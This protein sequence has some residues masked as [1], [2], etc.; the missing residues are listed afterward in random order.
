MLFHVPEHVGY[1]ALFLLIFIECAGVPVPGE[2]ALLTAGVLAGTGRLELSLVIATA[3]A[4]AMLGDNMGYLI[5]RHG[6]RRVL[7]R[8]GPMRHHRVR[9]VE[10]GEAFFA[11]HGAKTVFVGRWIAGV[12]IAGAV[13]A[14]ASAMPWRVFLVFNALG[15]IAWSATVAGFAAFAGPVATGTLYVAG[16]AIA[17][18][19]FAWAAYAGRRARA[20]QP[21]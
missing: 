19:T 5:G 15:A 11:R 17:G 10:R 14:G 12:R 1:G 8:G 6:G 13:L 2:T 7:L 4:A 9:A 16:L 20:R 3:A 21:Q 18:A